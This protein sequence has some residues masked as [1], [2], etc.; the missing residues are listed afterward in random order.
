MTYS[1]I[2]FYATFL[3]SIFRYTTFLLAVGQAALRRQDLA[4]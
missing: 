4:H 3:I 1:V 2:L